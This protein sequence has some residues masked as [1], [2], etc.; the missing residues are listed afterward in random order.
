VTHT[1]TSLNLSSCSV[2]ELLQHANREQVAYHLADDRLIVHPH[3]TR[4]DIVDALLARAEEVRAFLALHRR[5][6]WRT[7]PEEEA[8][9]RAR[10]DEMTLAMFGMEWQALVNITIDSL[11]ERVGEAW[12]RHVARITPLVPD[13]CQ[14]D[15]CEGGIQ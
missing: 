10:A 3:D 11:A 9:R 1:L 4:R 14:W 2:L 6:V 12:E 8:Y 7:P 5:H 15:G 13:A